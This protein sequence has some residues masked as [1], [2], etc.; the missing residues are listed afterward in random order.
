MNI[1]MRTYLVTQGDRSRGRGTGSI[2]RAAI[3]GG[4]D[5][6]QMRE[7][8]TSARERYEL[9]KELR[10]LTREADI[11]FV[12]ND[13]VD[14]AAAVDADGVHLG[15][16]D[17]PV[18]VARDHLGEEAIIGRSVSTPEAASEAERAGAD[19]LGVGAVF[20][21]DTKDVNEGEAEIGT[22]TIAEIAETV[23]IPIV[24]IGGINADNAT[25][26]VNAGAAGVAVVTTITDADDPAAATQ[27]L[28]QAVE[29]GRTTV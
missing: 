12:V 17:L 13:R 20:A 10:A 23:D 19:Y 18:S 28:R 6:V 7:K 9:G 29:N 24:G 21:T 3:E 4:V 14:I 5:I 2:V 22:E 8:H 27:Q 1:P 16:D 15:D 25:E 26:V 11:P